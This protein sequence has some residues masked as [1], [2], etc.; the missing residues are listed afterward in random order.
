VASVYA[1]LRIPAGECGI[2]LCVDGLDTLPAIQADESQ[3]FNAFYNLVNNAIPEVPPGGSVTVKGRTEREG[4]SIVVSVIDTGKGMP[5][6]V[7][8]S[9]FT[10]QAISRKVGGTGLGT[11]IVKDI[12]D[13]HRGGITVESKPGVGTSFHL[14]LP[15]EAVSP[16]DQTP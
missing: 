13:A 16:G 9:L 4:Q 3:L 11:K 2:A 10:Y 8:E 6:E 1:I 14:T 5:P 7:R 15:V 12:V